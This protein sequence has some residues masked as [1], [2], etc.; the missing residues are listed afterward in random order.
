VSFIGRPPVLGG[1]LLGLGAALPALMFTIGSG[2]GGLMAVPKMGVSV[3]AI[4]TG[5]SILVTW[6][7]GGQRFGL[8]G[9]AALTIGIAL[10]SAFG[11]VGESLKAAQRDVAV[12][13]CLFGAALGIGLGVVLAWAAVSAIPDTAVAKVAIPY[14]SVLFTVL[15]AVLAGVLAAV[16]PARRASTLNV[17]DAIATPS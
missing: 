9:S 4:V 2:W 7:R 16:I 13:F 11:V 3:V 12:M 14:E 1:G 15:I 6:L 17:L 5:S 8:G 10:V